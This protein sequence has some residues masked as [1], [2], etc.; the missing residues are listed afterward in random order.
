MSANSTPKRAQAHKSHSRDIQIPAFRLTTV[1][2]AILSHTRGE[3]L[4]VLGLN[5][6]GVAKAITGDPFLHS[7]PAYPSWERAAQ[8][9]SARKLFRLLWNSGFELK[10]YRSRRTKLTRRT[11]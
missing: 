3:D 5:V 7:R 1:S 11:I 2:G 9:S 4:I 8:A 6:D 10:L